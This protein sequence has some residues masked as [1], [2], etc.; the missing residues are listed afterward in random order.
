[1]STPNYLIEAANLRGC[2]KL[3]KAIEFI[4]KYLESQPNDIDAFLLRA[5]IELDIGYYPD[6]E[7]SSLK[8][9]Q[10]NPQS[11]EGNFLCGI[12]ALKMGASKR[13]FDR[14]N[15]AEAQKYPKAEL[16]VARAECSNQLRKFRK[17]LNDCS[18]AIKLGASEEQVSRMQWFA[19]VGL[20]DIAER[21][22]IPSELKTN[23]TK[24]L[25]VPMDKSQLTI[26]GA[27]Q[28]HRWQ[29]QKDI[30]ISTGSI[31]ACDPLGLDNF[32][33]EEI[34]FNTKFPDGRFPCYQLKRSDNLR[35]IGIVF[36]SGKVKDWKPAFDL[37]GQMHETSIDSGIMC[38]MSSSYC[39]LLRK[40]AEQEKEKLISNPDADDP[41]N[42]VCFDTGETSC[43]SFIG[44][45]SDK[46][47]IL[48]LV[49]SFVDSRND[50][51]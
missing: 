51:D 43:S 50:Y 24:L 36:G 42:I 41:G 45:G 23:L 21:A 44:L 22:K 1:M 27:S 3:T 15:A 49:M 5:R 47:Q 25:S 20:A 34:T 33:D 17:A 14:F 26:P 8:A 32:S 10:I 35:A 9:L 37:S 46:T 31:V 39:Q 4:D 29:R 13:A 40:L 2:G 18:A 7:R 30:V 48:A 11:G 38:F 12:A 28:R 19:N 6:A 16:Y